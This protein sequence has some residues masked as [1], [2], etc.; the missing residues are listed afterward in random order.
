M[1][2]N[3]LKE[4][5]P[6]GLAFPYS[7]KPLLCRTKDIVKQMSINNKM[8]YIKCNSCGGRVEL[9]TDEKIGYCLDCGKN[10]F[11]NHM[12]RANTKRELGPHSRSI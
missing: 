12:S 1:V 6:V 8:I 5:M 4:N 10:V 3:K 11:I 7:L 9:W 2:V